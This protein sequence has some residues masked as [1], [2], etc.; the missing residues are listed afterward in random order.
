LNG[1]LI[2]TEINYLDANKILENKKNTKTPFFNKV[3]D[4]VHWN[5]NALDVMYKII[6]KKYENN[7][8][9]YQIDGVNIAYT[10]QHREMSAGLFGK[11][12]VP[13]IELNKE[14]LRVK[15]NNI[16]ASI[17]I[18]GFLAISSLMRN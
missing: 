1:I 16:K 5:G 14:A 12:I 10:I 13:W 15:K 17:C 2:N 6:S 18:L 3:F 8:D 11:E 9:Y 7:P 4:I